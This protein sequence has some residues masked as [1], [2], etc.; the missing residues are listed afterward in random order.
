M[1]AIETRLR[2]LEARSVS[3]QRRTFLFGEAGPGKAKMQELLAAGVAHEDDLFI[4]TGV[5]QS[6]PSSYAVWDDDSSRS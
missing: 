2:K 4:F 6:D 5:P 1:A 3:H